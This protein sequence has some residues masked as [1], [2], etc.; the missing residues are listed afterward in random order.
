M[1]S[2]YKIPS[3]V[4]DKVVVFISNNQLFVE[5]T[6]AGKL[7]SGEIPEKPPYKGAKLSFFIEDRIENRGWIGNLIGV[8]PER[9]ASNL[10]VRLTGDVWRLICGKAFEGAACST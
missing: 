4:N 5:S 2:K 3:I 1:S 10:D 7:F 6:K 8:T 9:F